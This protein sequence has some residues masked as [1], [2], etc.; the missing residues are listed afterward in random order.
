MCASLFPL[1][2]T[3]FER[4]ML[5][6]D[7]PDYPMTCAAEFGFSGTIRRETFSE[8]FRDVLVRHPLLSARVDRSNRQRPCW[9]P[10][11]GVGPA[12]EWR[13]I[14]DSATFGLND[15]IDLESEAGMRFQVLEHSGDASATMFFHHACCDGI[16]AAR[17][18]EDLLT[19]YHLRVDPGS[20]PDILRD[21]DTLRL[22]VR[23][24]I[25]RVGRFPARFAQEV[26]TFVR[27]GL[28]WLYHPPSPLGRPEG[29]HDADSCSAPRVGFL[30]REFDAEFS[31]RLRATAKRRGVTINDVLVA[32]LFAAVCKWNAGYPSDASTPWLRIAVPQNLR[33]PADRWMPA[34][35]KVTMCFLTR[36]VPSCGNTSKLLEGI[37][38]EMA[39]ARY[40]LRGKGLIR[41]MGLAQA[42]PVLKRRFLEQGRCLATVVLSNLGDFDRWFCS[43]LP[44]ERNCVR[45]GDIC[46]ERITLVAPVRPRTHAAFCAGSYG[47]VLRVS[48]RPDPRFFTID[49]AEELLTLYASQL[50]AAVKGPPD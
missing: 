6:D 29:P 43:S 10:A 11:G 41:A 50:E 7:R 40:W 20:R 35:N 44:R 36:T 19:G 39:A 15:R 38:V 24:R 48:M 33:E 17:F 22:P 16:G 12:I 45:A 13:E 42:V 32:A 14:D 2:L 9:V 31:S 49:R 23:G 46:L 5:L 3:V 1:P 28:H 34:A 25:P 8:V 37:G 21:A 18:V 4:H 26:R 27:E 30:T 47:G